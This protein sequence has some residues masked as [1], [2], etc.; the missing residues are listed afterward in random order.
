MS[1]AIPV[2]EAELRERIR[3]AGEAIPDW[4]WTVEE[5]RPFAALLESIVAARRQDEL[6]NV[7]YLAGRR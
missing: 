4:T 1:V 2:E 5:L 6:G 7:V 3:L